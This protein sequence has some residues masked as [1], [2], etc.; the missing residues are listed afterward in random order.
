MQKNR[1]ACKKKQDELVLPRAH[2]LKKDHGQMHGFQIMSQIQEKYSTP[3]QIRK[4]HAGELLEEIDGFLD[5]LCSFPKVQK[6]YTKY[7]S[8]LKRGSHT[9]K[10]TYMLV[11]EGRASVCSFSR[12]CMFYLLLIV[13]ILF[14]TLMLMKYRDR[15]V[16][17]EDKENALEEIDYYEIL[18]IPTDQKGIPTSKIKKYYREA[19]YKVHPDRNRDCEEC[20]EKMAKVSEAYNMLMNPETRSFHDEYGVRPPD[21][22][23]KRGEA[24]FGGRAGKKHFD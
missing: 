1:E 4:Q 11:A 14:A 9:R 13:G 5:L 10:R 18:G 17:K 21:K 15:F 3:A 7:Y 16:I 20:P 23:M 22:L 6:H 12:S 2:K 19:A 8:L 24:R